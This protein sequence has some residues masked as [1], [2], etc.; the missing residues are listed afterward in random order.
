MYIPYISASLYP[1]FFSGSKVITCMHNKSP[2]CPYENVPCGYL[3]FQIMLVSCPIIL[4]F[5]PP[6]ITYCAYG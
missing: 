4:F 2:S 5:T 6:N 3:L 1:H